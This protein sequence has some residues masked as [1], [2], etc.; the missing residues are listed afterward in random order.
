MTT[1]S[2][3]RV[4]DVSPAECFRVLGT[5]S[6]GRVAIV[7]DDGPRVFPVN[8]ALDHDEI[9]FRTDPSSM[10]GCA[11]GMRAAFEIDGFDSAYH[12]GWS[13]LIVGTLRVET[14]PARVRALDRFPLR[15]WMPGA[16]DRWMRVIPDTITGRRIT[17]ERSAGTNC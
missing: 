14:D 15:P 10:L 5:F 11:G 6:L 8:Y 12:E 2:Y 7:A 17:H 9:V 4:C 3:P 13:V 16:K 1:I